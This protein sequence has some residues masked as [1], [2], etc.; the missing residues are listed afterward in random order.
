M[1][2]VII[3]IMLTVTTSK[4]YRFLWNM[5]FIC[6]ML[7][8]CA[9]MP[10]AEPEISPLEQQRQQFVYSADS[11]IE[12]AYGVTPNKIRELE[13]GALIAIDYPTVDSNPKITDAV[14]KYIN[15]RLEEFRTETQNMGEAN[16]QTGLYTMRITYKPYIAENGTVCFKF[17]ENIYS[18]MTNREDY[19]TALAFNGT[20][21]DPIYIDELF[22]PSTNYLDTLADDARAY[23]NRE[24]AVNEF[25]NTDLFSQGTA[26][27][28][29]NYSNFVIMPGHKIAFYF[30]KNTIAPAEAGAI[31]VVLPLSDFFDVLNPQFRAEIYG[32]GAE[33]SAAPVRSAE[34]SQVPSPSSAN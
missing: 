5:L 16:E 32:D 27:N 24:E 14:T 18:G 10:P 30:N 26:P 17:T 20:T 15:R 33:V 6:A 8:G 9:V 23:L 28:I 29:Q 22:N 21:G 34:Q 1:C 13:G 7:W 3:L 25:L 11:P 31:S 19:I 4:K 2:C 12:D